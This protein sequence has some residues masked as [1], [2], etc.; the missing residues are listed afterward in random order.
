VLLGANV[1]ITER[2]EAEEQEALLMQEVDHRAK[3]VLAV[4]LSL[5]RLT[6]RDDPAAFARAVEG[7][8]LAM[9]RV[10]TLL[11]QRHWTF[12]D[13]KEIVEAELRAYASPDGAA[14]RRISIVGPRARLAP[15]VA[16]SMSVVVH[17]L[18]T[19]AAKYGA[20]SVSTG[21]VDVSW[22]LSAE[23]IRLVWTERGGPHVAGAPA[24]NGFGARL[25]EATLRH[26]LGGEVRYDW[27]SSGLIATLTLPTGL[28]VV[29]V[30]ASAA[31]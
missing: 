30:T 24:R 11:A 1:D 3:N 4:V 7:R 9:S 21:R 2:H 14:D 15:A 26:Q 20:L 23:V 31:D 10:H 28:D 19:N 25:I 29:G 5:L 27:A 6:P 18:V 22:T 8:V 13:L 17:E 12:A 16:Q